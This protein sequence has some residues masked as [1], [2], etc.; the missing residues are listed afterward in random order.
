MLSSYCHS[1][2]TCTV[3]GASLSRS[4]YTLKLEWLPTLADLPWVFSASL[5]V[6]QYNPM[7]CPL[8][9]CENKCLSNGHKWGRLLGSGNEICGLETRLCVGDDFWIPNS[10]YP[11]C[12][13]VFVGGE[14]LLFLPDVTRTE[15]FQYLPLSYLPSYPPHLSTSVRLWA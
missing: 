3:L 15:S 10:L 5:S 12:F 11:F 2:R 14:T 4:V 6:T 8:C 1:N 9:S 7:A 13:L